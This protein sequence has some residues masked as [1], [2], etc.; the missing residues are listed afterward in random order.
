MQRHISTLPIPNGFK[1]KLANCG[2]EYVND[3]RSLK[4][5]DLIKGFFFTIECHLKP[6]L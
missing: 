5:T 1:T 4:P 3:L 2:I 6:I